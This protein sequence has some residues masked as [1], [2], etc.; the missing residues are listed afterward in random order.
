MSHTRSFTPIGVADAR[1][2]SREVLP[3]V[4]P[5]SSLMERS[6]P[7]TPVSLFTK[8][9][10]TASHSFSVTPPSCSRSSR[11]DVVRSPLRRRSHSSLELKDTSNLNSNNF[12]ENSKNFQSTHRLFEVD[13]PKKR[14][15]FSATVLSVCRV[16]PSRTLPRKINTLK[17]SDVFTRT[18]DFIVSVFSFFKESRE[19]RTFPDAD[20][21][22]IR[23]RILLITIYCCCQYFLVTIGFWDSKIFH[24]PP[25]PPLASDLLSS[26]YSII[27]HEL[28]T[29]FISTVHPHVDGHPHLHHSLSTAMQR[30]LG[31]ATVEWILLL[32]LFSLT[33]KIR[34]DIF[35]LMVATIFFIQSTGTYFGGLHYKTPL[36]PDIWDFIFT[37]LDVNFIHH[38]NCPS[39]NQYSYLPSNWILSYR[40]IRCPTSFPLTTNFSSTFH[41]FIPFAYLIIYIIDLL[42]VIISSIAIIRFLKP[43][44]LIYPGIILI[45]CLSICSYFTG[46]IPK[47]NANDNHWINYKQHQNH[48]FNLPS[49]IPN[50]LYLT[51]YVPMS[52]GIELAA[53]IYLPQSS[54]SPIV[55][56]IYSEYYKNFYA[57]NLQLHIKNLNISAD[58]NLTPK[59]P[60][61]LIVTRYNRR[62]MVRWPFTLLSFWG[63]SHS[64][65]TI[66]VWSWQFVDV[67]VSNGYAV[68]SIDARGTG[69]SFGVRPIDFSPAEIRD[70]SEIYLWVQQQF[71][72]NGR[73]S[74][75]G[76]SY[77]GMTG[78]P[79]TILTYTSHF[80]N[81]C[82]HFL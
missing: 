51:K 72:S 70:L 9:S 36:F 14:S 62:M 34:S 28:L 69:A 53:D 27:D 80:I 32:W 10:R 6:H 73:I 29:N 74:A 20:L 12:S 77:D 66:N 35:G 49:Q 75:G 37:R 15:N 2:K 16:Q 46:S 71:W 63:Q 33:H 24:T 19:K 30:C 7:K 48:H 57:K 43:K 54:I 64:S 17:Y 25:P 31:M 65:S 68:V 47:P 11:L 50:P 78:N 13:A 67:L 81:Y 61:F 39:F 21:T 58:E 26:N 60:T 44:L 40:F 42:S 82:F 8:M 3:K 55:T 23:W 45:I 38:N 56:K 52:D 4:L 22:T 1:S 5:L 59:I 41:S 79:F 18:L 76:F